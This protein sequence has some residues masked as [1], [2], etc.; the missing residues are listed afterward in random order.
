MVL[1]GRAEHLEQFAWLQIPSAEAAEHE[2]YLS[3]LLA[4]DN[5]SVA[6][7]EK[8]DNNSNISVVHQR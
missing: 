8:R 1:R 4:D 7:K 5:L 3:N 2:L 6:G